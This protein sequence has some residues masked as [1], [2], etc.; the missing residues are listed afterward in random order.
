[1]LDFPKLHLLSLSPGGAHSERLG[2]RGITVH[3]RLVQLALKVVVAVLMEIWKKLETELAF[4]SV[5]DSSWVTALPCSAI[6]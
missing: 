3:Y 6:P 4:P 5:S 2:W 1:L